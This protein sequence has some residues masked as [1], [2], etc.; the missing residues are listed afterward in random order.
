[1]WDLFGASMQPPVATG[2]GQGTGEGTCNAGPITLSQTLEKWLQEK[3]QASL[4]P[5]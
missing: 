2:A 1:M 3:S 5:E 4:T